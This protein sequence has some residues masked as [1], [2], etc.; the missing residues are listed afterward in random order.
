MQTSHSPVYVPARLPAQVTLISGRN[1]LR[2]LPAIRVAFVPGY[3]VANSSTGRAICESLFRRL[4]LKL[5][6]DGGA[7]GKIISND[8]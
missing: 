5:T 4:A 6:A 8:R 2:Q 1:E 3:S 7:F